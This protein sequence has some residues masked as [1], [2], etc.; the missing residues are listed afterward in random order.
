MAEQTETVV[1]QAEVERI[2]ESGVD[3]DGA[4]PDEKPEPEKEEGPP[5]QELAR[6]YVGFGGAGG[7]GS[8]IAGSGPIGPMPIA[9]AR[10]ALAT[11][12][13]TV[14]GFMQQLDALIERL[15]PHSRH[16]SAALAARGKVS[17][18][19]GSLVAAAGVVAER[20]R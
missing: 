20:P 1:E 18:A 19:Y 4:P 11:A 8:A 5:A 10:V 14:A 13:L 9:Q 16:R 17:E 12:V 7:F 2:L 6:D 15:E 3:V